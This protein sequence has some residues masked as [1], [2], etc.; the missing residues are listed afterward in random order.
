MKNPL[1]LQLALDLIAT[2]S[3]V[4]NAVESFPANSGAICIAKFKGDLPEAL[5]FKFDDNLR[6]QYEVAVPLLRSTAF[7]RS[8]TRSL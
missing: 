5:S 4:S 2:V 3:L 6:D 1:L 7:L 8:S